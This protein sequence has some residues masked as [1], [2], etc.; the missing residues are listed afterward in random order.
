MLGTISSASQE[1]PEKARTAERLCL[2]RTAAASFEAC[3]G[4]RSTRLN[5][6][7]YIAVTERCLGLF[8]VLRLVLLFGYFD[9]RRT[10][11]HRVLRGEHAR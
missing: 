6:E 2:A 5:A 9:R 11:R 8:H 1:A 4:R 7:S 3:S 10:L